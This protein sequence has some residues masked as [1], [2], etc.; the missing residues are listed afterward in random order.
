MAEMFH[1]S[2]PVYIVLFH[3]GKD[4]Y[5]SIPVHICIISPRRRCLL[6]HPGTHLYYFTK[7]EMFIIPSRS[8]I[9]VV[10]PM[11][12][13]LL[14]PPGFDT[15]LIASNT[16]Y[17]EF[18]QTRRLSLSPLHKRRRQEVR[19]KKEKLNKSSELKQSQAC[20]PRISDVSPGVQEVGFIASNYL[21]GPVHRNSMHTV[22]QKDNTHTVT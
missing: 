19:K 13:S 20:K 16:T 8:M 6:F 21:C 22:V 5:Y 2:I 4:V 1:Y 10:P 18:S 17:T 14:F 12:T 9:F 11:G 3:Q 15:N 7:G